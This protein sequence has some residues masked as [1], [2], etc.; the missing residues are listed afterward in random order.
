[1]HAAIRGHRGDYQLA[2]RSLHSG[3][4]GDLSLFPLTVFGRAGFLES[5]PEAKFIGTAKFCAL[6]ELID[7]TVTDMH[8]SLSSKPIIR[9]KEEKPEKGSTTMSA[10]S[11]MAAPRPCP[12]L[13]SLPID[14]DMTAATLMPSVR[15]GSIAPPFLGAAPPPPPVADGQQPPSQPAGDG[16]DGGQVLQ[17]PGLPYMPAGRVQLTAT[18]FSC[19]CRGRR[20][21][22]ASN[23]TSGEV[24]VRF[25]TLLWC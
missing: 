20:I 19:R 18:R 13:S 15:L 7:A 5:L 14:V 10:G 4:R 2:P 9:L 16:I 3:T 21:L 24:A 22:K 23:G 25:F 6:G 12:V 8:K 17:L 11:T 1:M